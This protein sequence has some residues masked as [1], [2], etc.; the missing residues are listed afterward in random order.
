MEL[1]KYQTPLTE[2]ILSK[3]PDEVVDE[4]FGYI[5]SVPFIQN[6]ISTDRQ[7]A[8][9]RPRD[10][11]GKIIVDLANP[12]ILE[13]MD[14]FRESAIHYNR[15]GRFT[16]LRVNTA[17]QST[18]MKWFRREVWRCWN[19]MVRE[20]DGEWIP[21]HLYYYLN[22]FPIIQ[23]KQIKGTDIADRVVDF[24]EIWEGVYWRFHYMEQGRFGGLY[25]SFKGGQHGCEIASRGKS[26]SY[27]L[28]SIMANCFNN[29]L[30]SH[31][32]NKR[33]NKVKCLALAH[34]EEFLN[35]DA[36]LNKFVEG[37]NFTRDNTEFPS[38]RLKDSLSDLEWVQGHRLNTGQIIGSGNQILGLAIA[39]DPDK[40]R[41]KRSDYMFFEEFG[42]FPKFIDTLMTTRANVQ[43]MSLVF[44]YFYGIG[45]GGSEGSDFSGA[46]ELIINPLGYNIY[47]IPNVYDKGQTGNKKTIFFFPSYVNSK[48]YYN[49]DGVSDV[50]GAMLAEL[51][52][53][54]TLKYN[55]SDPMALTRQKAEFAF[56]LQDAIMR[57][58][59]TVYPVADINERILQLDSDTRAYDDMSVGRLDIRD[60][61]VIFSP[62]NDVL[63]IMHYPH[64]DSKLEGAVF[65]NHMPE[66]DSSGE[67]PWGRYIAG[68]DPIVDDE[69]TQSL[70]LFSIFVLDLWTDELVCEY[71]G[72]NV[73]AEE[74]FEVARRVCLFYNAECN[75]ENNKK[76]LYTH[77][78][79]MNSLYLLSDVLQFLKDKEMMKEGSFNKSKGTLATAAIKGYGRT[80]YRDYLIKPVFMTVKDEEGIEREISVRR[81]FTI[82]YKAL[83]QE[84]SLWNPDGNFDRHDAIVML[85]LIREDKLR[86]L[87]DNSFEDKE[88]IEKDYLGNDPFFESNYRPSRG[89]TKSK[90][91]ETYL[92][93]IGVQENQEEK[94]EHI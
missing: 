53:R 93:A 55:S 31:T 81:L 12:H 80:A 90:E 8:K 91:F 73:L 30:Y 88:L 39:N 84:T 42:N 16:N 89:Y 17:P 50:I 85:M 64:K 94:S 60:G 57:R 87:G 44:G 5:N 43:E 59:S 45:T 21:G 86:L 32:L 83:L 2:D 54:Y 77:F 47:G 23:S 27:S 92:K 52:T 56:T 76:G 6:L 38:A 78:S 69:V 7:Y 58:D 40:P 41:G 24:P 26:K 65:I 4:L 63:P 22:Y 62:S 13:N 71:T 20:S 28:A 35:G 37:I 1:N 75:Y 19:G 49:E 70:S 79:K 18:Y 10:E 11:Q 67:I 74:A 3:Y 15:F 68:V 33:K 9:D 29:G 25:N 61:K 72:R 14:Y 46:M 36:L 34:S 51:M 82:K 66:K 48:P